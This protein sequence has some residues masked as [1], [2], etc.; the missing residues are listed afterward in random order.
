MYK[1]I[2]PPVDPKRSKTGLGRQENLHPVYQPGGSMES[3]LANLVDD[4]DD[5]IYYSTDPERDFGSD[6]YDAFLAYVQRG[7]GSTQDAPTRAQFLLVT[8]FFTE[9]RGL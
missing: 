3:N 4:H 1:V 2:N 5:C 8:E 6:E 7:Y 9:E